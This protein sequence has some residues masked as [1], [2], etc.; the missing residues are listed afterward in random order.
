[1]KV[2]PMLSRHL[3]LSGS[4]GGNN[5]TKNMTKKQLSQAASN[6]AKARWQQKGKESNGLRSTHNALISTH[7]G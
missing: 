2:S 4:K 3:S 5:R 7:A 6:S 1:M